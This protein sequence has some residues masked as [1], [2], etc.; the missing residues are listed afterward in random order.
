[1]RNVRLKFLPRYLPTDIALHAGV[2]GALELMALHPQQIRTEKLVQGGNTAT[3]GVG[4]N[5][6]RASAAYGKQGLEFRV[7]AVVQIRRL[8]GIRRPK[9][10]VHLA[11]SR[12]PVAL[13]IQTLSGSILCVGTEE[14][15][16]IKMNQ[17]RGRICHPHFR[18]PGDV[19]QVAR[20]SRLR[21][22]CRH[23]D[24]TCGRIGKE[25]HQF[26]VTFGIHGAVT[27]DRFDQQQPIAINIVQY[28]IWH[29]AMIV[30][31]DTEP[32]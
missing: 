17:V 19:G 23:I 10:K 30:N 20:H 11:V 1:M 27:G 3:T 32:P 5:S 9:V 4:G 26:S 12:Y 13:L 8:T 21:G 25:R 14:A 18:F 24:Q 6:T 2:E 28:N 7:W 31:C 15:V 22:E 29:L 16:T